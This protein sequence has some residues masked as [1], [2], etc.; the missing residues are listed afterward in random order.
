MC[1]RIIRSREPSSHFCIQDSTQQFKHDCKYSDYP[2]VDPSVA[3]IMWSISGCKK[4]LVLT[5]QQCSHPNVQLRDCTWSYWV[6]SCW[7]VRENALELFV[8]RAFQTACLKTKEWLTFSGK[9]FGSVFICSV[10]AGIQHCGSAGP[11]A[12]PTSQRWCGVRRVTLRW[13]SV[14][15]EELDYHVN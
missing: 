15:V 3:E 14:T 7:S 11:R 13:R 9:N 2:S 6:V 10:P 8:R 12:A 1:R 5:S 4:F